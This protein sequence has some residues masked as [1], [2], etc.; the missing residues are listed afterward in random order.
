MLSR[1]ILVPSVSF[2]GCT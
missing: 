1:F 2:A